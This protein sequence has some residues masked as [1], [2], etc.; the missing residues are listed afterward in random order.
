[1]DRSRLPAPF[2]VDGVSAT[3]AEFAHGAEVAAG[4]IVRDARVDFGAAV[5]GP[6]GAVSA[7][8]S[9]I[10]A[11]ADRRVLVRQF[12]KHAAAGGTV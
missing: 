5:S 4:D 7:D 12:S 8:R 6:G 9:Q 1:M 2:G 11:E 10:R 3:E